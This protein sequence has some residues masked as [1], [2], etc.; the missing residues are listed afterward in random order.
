LIILNPH[1]DAAVSE[2]EK[3]QKSFDIFS[4][5]ISETYQFRVLTVDGPLAVLLSVALQQ[6]LEHGPFPLLS[7]LWRYVA[8]TTLV[9]S[10]EEIGSVAGFF[11]LFVLFAIW[12]VVSAWMEKRSLLIRLDVPKIERDVYMDA[13]IKYESQLPVEP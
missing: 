13:K 11:V 1:N 10:S 12:I 2:V 8:G 5:I 4:K 9:L 3:F 6:A 7:F